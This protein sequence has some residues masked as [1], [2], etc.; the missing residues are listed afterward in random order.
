MP[1]DL[2]LSVLA[3][4]SYFLQRVIEILD[5]SG[6]ILEEAEAEEACRA[7]HA[8]IKSYAWLALKAHDMRLALFKVRPKT[9]YLYHVGDSIKRW[10]LNFNAFHVFDDEAFLG[11]IKSI[12]VKVHGSTLTLRV[13]QRYCLCLALYLHQQRQ[14][15]QRLE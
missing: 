2:I 1:D 11:K 9:H 7:V 6:L 14:L 8:H 4:C 10:R 3:T 12:A 5:Q 13:F 15:E